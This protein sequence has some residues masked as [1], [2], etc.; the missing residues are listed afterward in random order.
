VV[1]FREIENKP[2]AS[3][4]TSADKKAK[5]SFAKLTGDLPQNNKIGVPAMPDESRKLLYEEA[6]AYIDEVLNALRNRKGFALKKGFEIIQKIVARTYPQ[7][8]VLILALHQDDWRRYVTQH[9]VNVAV[10]TLALKSRNRWKSVW[11]VYCMTWG[12]PWF[13][14]KFFISRA[15]STTRRKRFSGSVPIPALRFYGR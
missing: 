8:P 4:G 14:I 5:L 2:Q 10:F 6:S 11:P 13:R 7:D 15:S 9:P 1:Q 12:W 3:K